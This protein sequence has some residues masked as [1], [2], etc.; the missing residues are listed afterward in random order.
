[1]KKYRIT[2]A[3]DLLIGKTGTPERNQ[4]E[5]EL[6][7]LII[8]DLIRSARKARKLTQEELGARIG[9]K[10]AQISRLENKTGNFTVE[11][12][13]NVFDALGAKVSL[14]IRFE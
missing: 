12:L 2:E 4:Y 9:V 13:L 6:N 1:M 11:T 7:L 8:G 10:K 14:K 5:Y 3:E